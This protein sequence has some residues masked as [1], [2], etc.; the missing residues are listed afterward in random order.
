MIYNNA[1]LLEALTSPVRK[2]GFIAQVFLNGTYEA[3][4]THKDKI[5]SLTIDR[6]GEDGKFFG[7]GVCHKLNLKL[8]DKDRE[9]DISTANSIQLYYSCNSD[10]TNYYVAPMFYVTD[11]YRDENTNELSITAYDMLYKAANYTMADLGLE[12]YS[13]VD[14]LIAIITKLGLPMSLPMYGIDDFDTYVYVNGANF[15]GSET[16]REV[17]DAIGEIVQGIYYLNHANELCFR[18]LSNSSDA[19]FI[20]N[21]KDY[22][23][24]ETGTNRRLS[25]I[26]HTTDLGD[27][28]SATTGV[29]G[30][31]QYIR[32]N[33]FW[34][35]RDDIADLLDTAIANVGGLTIGQFECEWRGIPDLQVGDKIAIITKNDQVI[36]SY[37]LNDTLNYDGTLSQLTKWEY[38]EEEGETTSNPT[39]IGDAIKQTYAKVD[40][41]E[42]EIT[43]LASEASENAEKIAALQINT[44]SISASVTDV[45]NSIDS[46]TGSLEEVTSK[47]EATM[48][49]EDI[50]IA[51][52]TEVSN[53]V[54]KVTTATGF[55]FNDDGLTVSKTDSEMKTTIT[56]DGMVVYKNDEA[57]LTANNIGVDA[58]NLHATTYLIIGT[59]S[60]FEDFGTDRTGCFWIGG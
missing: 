43:L 18:R 9:I 27:N 6:I 35:L 42:K 28:V 4:Y 24:L 14:V 20:I 15:S 17:L 32:S 53:G 49:A 50:Q 55:T 37:L 3:Q 2:I 25:T 10:S 34:D 16:L 58:V 21:K 22:I 1:E 51:I 11:V 45:K 33:P 40:K 12:S 56:E 38:A 46:V 19:D 52:K 30:T 39:T 47:V 36:Y 54:D 31:T 8:L 48:T 23:T 57:V 59:N 26:V 5:T 44:E 41:A 60:R 29:S 13:M 7:F